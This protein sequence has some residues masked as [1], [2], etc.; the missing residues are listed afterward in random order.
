[1]R[2]TLSGPDEE[3]VFDD[4][5]LCSTG[6]PFDQAVTLPEAGSYQLIVNGSGADTGTYRV[7]I[8]SR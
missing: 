1:L 5:A 7:K 2:W 8:Q 3:P 4:E 6:S